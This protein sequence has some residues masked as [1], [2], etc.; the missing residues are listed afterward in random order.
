MFKVEFRV[1]ETSSGIRPSP[2]HSSRFPADLT[3]VSSATDVEAL[4]AEFNKAK[5]E[6]G[7]DY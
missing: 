1:V 6:Q 5:E 7:V 2:L 3:S 4:L